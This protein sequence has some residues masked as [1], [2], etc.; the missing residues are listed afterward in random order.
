LNRRVRL[1]L[2]PLGEP[3]P[4]PSASAAASAASAPPAA[5]EPEET[6]EGDVFC[7]QPDAE[8]AAVGG[9]GGGHGGVVVLR[10]QKQHT[11]QKADYAVVALAAIA[12]V[13][14]LGAGRDAPPAA[15]DFSQQEVEAR[16]A[17]AAAREEQR[18]ARRGGEGV[19]AEDQ[20]VFDK[21]A[22]NFPDARW[23]KR[24]IVMVDSQ[25]A[26]E[27]PYAL[28]NVVT[29][30]G[31]DPQEARRLEATVKQR[32]REVLTKVRA[33]LGLSP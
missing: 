25:I 22:A 1:T 33:D 27:P 15:R 24:V 2:K 18:L 14:D 6:V 29:A 19:T 26:I 32:V 30:S 20:R 10:S 9:G 21:L 17:G 4:P 13:E 8:A 23:A 7:V 3:P 12:R 28:A 31:V 5:A 16:Y 11:Y